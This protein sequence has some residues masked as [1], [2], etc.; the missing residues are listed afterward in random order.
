MLPS[1]L[2]INFPWVTRKQLQLLHFLSPWRV[3]RENAREKMVSQGLES[4]K[5]WFS[6]PRGRALFSSRVFFPF[7]T[8]H[9][10]AWKNEGLLTLFSL[11]ISVAKMLGYIFERGMLCVK[12][13]GRTNKSWRS[14]HNSAKQYIGST[15]S[16]VQVSEAPLN[17][18]QLRTKY[19]KPYDKGNNI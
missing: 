15:S 16:I 2:L 18:P 19:N 7:V 4:S 9:G 13:F 5:K 12:H 3:T 8:R 1:C 11:S 10:P 17:I 6:R 14:A